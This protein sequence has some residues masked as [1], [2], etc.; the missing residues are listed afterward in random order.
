MMFTSKYALAY[1]HIIDYE[2]RAHIF[3]ELWNRVF[4]YV[5]GDSPGERL[6]V[7][8]IVLGEIVEGEIV[9]KEIVWGAIVRET[10]S[11]G[12]YL[13]GDCPRTHF[14]T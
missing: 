5:G 7:G 8:A 10:L 1:Q 3:L 12:D 13:G 14:I 4:Q 11:R 6:T 9:L 2:M